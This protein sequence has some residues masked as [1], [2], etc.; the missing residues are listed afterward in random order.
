MEQKELV[1]KIARELQMISD[2]SPMDWLM[3]KPYFEYAYGAGFDEGKAMLSHRVMVQQ[4]KKGKVIKIHRSFA[5]AARSIRG[6]A[7]TIC[8]VANNKHGHYTHKG[9]EWKLVTT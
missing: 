7:S 4:I 2:I 1:S 3:L 8:N 5:D 6:D 9:F